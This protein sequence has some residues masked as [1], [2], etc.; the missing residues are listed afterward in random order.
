[1]FLKFKGFNP[2]T[3]A[4]LKSSP[5]SSLVQP[6]GLDSSLVQPYTS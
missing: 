1:M 3:R 4:R 2:A 5:A 6:R